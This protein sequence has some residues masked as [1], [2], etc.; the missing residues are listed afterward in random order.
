MGSALMTT[1]FWMNRVSDFIEDMAAL[2]VHFME[3]EIVG[4]FCK[5]AFEPE[6]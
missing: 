1:S 6:D 5:M 4:N 2:K 3:L